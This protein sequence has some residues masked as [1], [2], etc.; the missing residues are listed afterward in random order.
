MD[1][2]ETW[3]NE[4]LT[5][6]KLMVIIFLTKNS[7]AAQSGT[8]LQHAVQIKCARCVAAGPYQATMPST[9]HGPFKT[10]ATNH[11]F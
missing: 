2:E 5:Y 10:A 3:V 6:P 7:G 4:G 11:N 1:L 8:A 9:H